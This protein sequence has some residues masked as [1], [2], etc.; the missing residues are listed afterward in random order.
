MSSNTSFS[1]S[2]SQSNSRQRSQSRKKI[3]NYSRKI[4]QEGQK[5]YMI[6]KTDEEIDEI[7]K[8][9]K[10]KKPGNAWALFISEKLREDNEAREK[11]GEAKLNIKDVINDYANEWK[12]LKDSEKQKYKD[13]YEE[14]KE[15]FA[16]ETKKVQYLLF[17]FAEEG[18]TAYKI[19]LNEQLEKGF[20]DGA[21]AKQ[22][23]KDASEKWKEMTAEEK[24]PYKEE[25]KKNDTWWARAQSA[26]GPISPYSIFIQKYKELHPKASFT[27]KEYAEKWNDL[28]KAE[29][30]KYVSYCKEAREQR[31]R[32]VEI[33]EISSGVKPH[34]P[35]GAFK[36]FIKDKI[37][38]DPEYFK[39]R[40][41]FKEGKEEFDKLNDEQKQV[42]LNQARREQIAYRY[43]TNIYRQNLRKIQPKRARSA[44]MIYMEEGDFSD[45]PEDVKLFTF[46][47][48]KFEKLSQ[49]DKDM[50]NQ[51]AEDDKERAEKEREDFRCRV[52]K[53]PG[54]PLSI[55]HL[56][57]RDR[58][59][60]L[61]QEAEENK[62][63]FVATEKIGEVT[64]AWKN[65]DNKEK[66]KF[67]R[68][69]KEAEKEYNKR[70]VS[71][72]SLGY[73]ID[74]SLNKKKDTKNKSQKKNSQSKDKKSQS[75]GKTQ[76]GKK[77]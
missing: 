35:M 76:R 30:Q 73:Y 18:A 66:A 20:Q 5:L 21:D 45:R 49:K 24:K 77:K 26:P 53:A 38:E 7:L 36:C 4:R 57:V 60:K 69:Y 11:K 9:V 12:K 14:E 22:V 55:Y 17:N 31:K 46:A 68:M 8:D 63:K 65:I 27:L 70:N 50:Y 52:Y 29:R 43:K 64:E 32:M 41:V 3:E 61:K 72:K 59:K 40:S 28:S 42:Y 34:K 47:R 48:Q 62:E 2:R 67:E 54:K 25:K 10:L 15:R 71:Y 51:K 75:R 39:G 58:M 1:Q 16:E 13:L 56:F 6:D 33:A 74:E 23:K 44:L 19:F 37:S